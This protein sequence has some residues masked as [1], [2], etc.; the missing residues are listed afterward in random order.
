LVTFRESP[1]VRN[2]LGKPACPLS[3]ETEIA[4]VIA[5][6]AAMLLN[7]IATAIRMLSLLL[8][9]VP[10][11]SLCNRDAARRGENTNVFAIA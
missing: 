6:I 4:A 10:A 2:E 7:P 1:G 8:M 5:M 9:K 3:A 11:S